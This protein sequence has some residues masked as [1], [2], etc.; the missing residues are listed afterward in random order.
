MRRNPMRGVNSTLR[1][2]ADLLNLTLSET[3]DIL[4]GM[5]IKGNIRARD[6]MESLKSVHSE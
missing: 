2:L 3:L 1:E 5:G 4:S 6:V